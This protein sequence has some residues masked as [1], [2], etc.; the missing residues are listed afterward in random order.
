MDLGV[1]RIALC[2]IIEGKYAV[3]IRAMR[4]H[5]GSQLITRKRVYGMEKFAIIGMACLFPEAHTVNSYW[6]NLLSGRDSRSIATQAQM[7]INPEE[8]FSPTRTPD[9]YYSMRGGYIHDF[10]FNPTGYKLSVD[11]LMALDE[12]HHWSLYAAHEALLDSGYADSDLFRTGVIMG[13]LSFPTRASHQLINSIYSDA[14]YEAISDLLDE[15]LPLQPLEFF[16][17]V[18]PVNASMSGSPAS[19]IA[20]A[21]GLGGTHFALDAACASSLYAVKLAC[22]YL[23]AGKADMM[24][25]GAVSRSDPYNINMG[26]SIFSAYP[27]QDETSS[28][29]N[30]HSAGLVAAEG[31]GFLVIKRLEDALQA[32]DKIV[33]V[34][35]GVGLS[36]DGRGKHLLTPN[37][38]GQIRA[39]ERAYAHSDIT[40]D[41]I[42]YV[43]CHATGTP[44]GDVTELN[45]MQSFFG[46]NQPL[47][48]SVK[49]NLGHLLTAAG[50]S[51]VMKVVLAMQHGQIPATL[52]ITDPLVSDKA[53]W[54][55]GQIVTQTADW[56]DE[57]KIGAV[58][59]FGFGGCNAHLILEQ[60]PL[61]Y[62]PVD[63][64]VRLSPMALVGMDAF[65]GKLDGLQAF[66][67]AIFDGE[68]AFIPLPHERWGGMNPTNVPVGTQATM[69]S[70][71][72]G[73]DVS[74]PYNPA[75]GNGDVPPLYAM[76]RGLGGGAKGAYMTS[77]EMDFLRFKIPP[78]ADDQPIPQQTLMLKVADRALHDA[79]IKEGGNVAVIIA[80]N[81]ELE[82][83]KFRGRVD[84]GWQIRDALARE[85]IALSEDELVRLES[86]ARDALHTWPGVNQYVSFIGNIVANR[87][88][89][90]WDF[91]GASFTLSAE[92]NGVSKALEIAQ[93][94]LT[95]GEADAV[96]VGAVDLS[97]GIENVMVRAQTAPLG[98]TDSPFGWDA[99]NNGWHIGEGAGAV[100]LKTVEKAE[101]DHNRIYAT[102]E[103]ISISHDT[104]PSAE[105]LANAID[106]VS[107]HTFI[108][109]K[110]IQFISL[111]ASGIEA[112]DE[113]EMLGLAYGYRDVPEKIALISSKAVIGHTYNASGMASLIQSA[114]VIHRRTLPPMPN[115]IKPK[116]EAFFHDK[117]FYIPTTTRP[118]VSSDTFYTYG[119]VTIMGADG[120]HAHIFMMANQIS[121][122]IEL[123]YTL[124][125][126][127]GD[128]AND[129]QARL[130]DVISQ[131]QNTTSVDSIQA[132]AISAY[133]DSHPYGGALIGK[134]RDELLSEAQS[135][136]KGIA[137]A[138]EKNR[139]WESK[140]GSS[141]TAKPATGAV[142]LVYPGAFNAYVGMA[143]DLL[144]NF[145]HLYDSSPI[146][147]HNLAS[148]VA[149]KLIYPRT[150]HRLSDEE[151][152][153]QQMALGDNLPAMMQA[154]ST[155]AWQYTRM[156][157]LLGIKPAS[158]LGYSMG[159]A[160]MMWGAEIWTD[161][162]QASYL[163]N[164]TNLFISKVV[165]KKTVARQYF[166]DY[167]TP[168]DALWGNYV[169]AT[170]PDTMRQ[171][172][173]DEPTVFMTHINTPNQVAIAGEKIACERVLG[174]IGAGFV[175][176]MPAVLHCPPTANAHA[177]F[178]RLHNL[179]VSPPPVRTAFMPSTDEDA[180]KRVPTGNPDN[181]PFLHE[182]GRGGKGERGI[183]LY[184][185]DGRT[186][187]I[188]DSN[189]LA[190]ELAH[191]MAQMVDF[192]KLINTAYH[193]GARI[194]IEVGAQ[195]T[196]TR[197]IRDILR[198]K[199]HVAV[200]TNRAGVSDSQS[201][202][203]L[204]AKLISHRV[205]MDLSVLAR[206]SAEATPN[207]KKRLIQKITLGKTPLRDAILSEENVAWAQ[208]L[209]KNFVEPTPIWR[210]MRVMRGQRLINPLAG[211]PLPITIEQ[212][213]DSAMTE[214]Q[215]KLSA[216]QEA[217][218]Q[219]ATQVE[220]A[221]NT[222]PVNESPLSTR[223]GGD[224]GVGT[225]PINYATP[226]HIIWDEKALEEF[227]TG[228]IA[229]V[230]G[231][232]YAI[233]DTYKSRV[234]LPAHPYLLVSRI[235][236]LDAEIHQYRPS[237]MTTEYDIPFDAWYSVDGQIPWAVSVESGQCDLMLI[238]YIGI[239][240]EV[241]GK[242]M[243]RL[244][245]CTLNFLKD[246]PK[247][248]HT[249]RYDIRINSY[250]RNGD[251]LLFFF[252]YDCYVGDEVV[253]T[254]RNG[255]AGFF[256][257]EDLD[258]G[259]GIIMTQ[260]E[261]D[262]RAQI[263][264]KRFEP[265]LHTNKRHFSKADLRKLS[266]G[267]IAGTFAD[268]AYDLGGKSPSLRLPAG[269][270]LL[271]DRIADV[272]PSG[273]AWGL[274][275]IIGEKDLHPTDW[276]FPCH[277]I[278][279]QVM[280]GSLV[281]EGCVQMMQV[282]MMYLGLHLTTDDARFQPI[283]GLPQ[284]VRCRGQVGPQIGKLI[285]RLEIKEIGTSPEPY[286][287]ADVDVILNG[288]IV[289]DFKDLGLKLS[290]KA[291]ADKAIYGRDILR[292]GYIPSLQTVSTTPIAVRDGIA[293][294]KEAFI[295]EWHLEQFAFGSI[296]DCFGEEFRLYDG[297]LTPR[298]PNSELK[299]IS[300]IL[301]VD[302]TRFT[303]DGEPSLI[304]EYDVP[305]DAWYYDRNHSATMPY[306]ILMEIGLQ[307]CGFL[308]AWLGSTLEYP[309]ETYFFR[310][311]DGD[312]KIH[313]LPDLRGK[314]LTNKVVLLSSTS[315]QGMIIQK[316]SYALSADGM[317]FYDGTASFG[318]FTGDALANQVGLDRGN[319][320]Y[321]WTDQNGIIPYVVDLTDEQTLVALQNPPEDKP[322][323]R[324]PPD[325]LI[326]LDRVDV[327]GDGGTHGMGYVHGYKTID[328]TN[329]FYRCHF[330]QDPVMPG[331]LGVEAI[332][333][334]LQVFA[335]TTGLAD[336]FASPRFD[337]L[338]D[339]QF[340]WKYRGQVVPKNDF[341]HLE[342]HISA[343]ERAD[344]GGI[345]LKGNANLWR[346]DIRI[347]EVRGVALKIS[348]GG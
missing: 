243:Y 152:T 345:I 161:A 330:Y 41:Q 42:Q 90:A 27:E 9:K 285:Y 171:A 43:E 307:P 104:R 69:P 219:L 6:E 62:T 75:D 299:L 134:N 308:S 193:D 191:D 287:I 119:A 81:G 54:G 86:I 233:I 290:E 176:A 150:T 232:E 263:V 339:H 56:S 204:I 77:F 175:V 310:N 32:G 179:P 31:A 93:M 225:R 149:D 252:E 155:F 48:G 222:P 266:M 162:N 106:A 136:Q 46:K 66:E 309:Q 98:T 216:H 332:L 253:L 91:S 159:E 322:T 215:D 268:S 168:D 343:I 105:A 256:S 318:Y 165:G 170:D 35:S 173:A 146:H 80:M 139:D 258:A 39:Y 160:S 323:F 23:S 196:C 33:A 294:M 274:G 11:D 247:E 128:S 213:Q 272:N 300:R 188:T 36:N 64:N 297:R 135:A 5:G 123:R 18:S 103:G 137:T 238:S 45:S 99:D 312:G 250:A 226:E 192:P 102:I 289:V 82:L 224:L 227:A 194:F 335:M 254:M 44:L 133:N 320:T 291:P 284:V 344:D 303:F 239:D 7:G 319:P 281:A 63:K 88:S 327:V 212:G 333:Q 111:S 261:R 200:A 202:A 164:T 14:V 107:H 184:G 60:S 218:R 305:L 338:D 236:K 25:A 125:P 277:F 40:P 199:P 117:P 61:E 181:S 317:V 58:S 141:F 78:A 72:E 208:S 190:H 220:A 94:M 231:Q 197:W 207:G 210:D 246:M 298:Q 114:L 251:N 85:G 259:K 147:S 13:N 293:I 53:N 283:H 302:G 156:V 167:T 334:A 282:Y 244:L 157:S 295:N 276:Y 127:S 172:L 113:A 34:V 49:G 26:F 79:Q 121:L 270:M 234:R 17:D 2:P 286:A 346:E 59:A 321:S 65:F 229:N 92:E 97:G 198:D 180:Q 217:L 22:D 331:S 109:P 140:I 248:G 55:A 326:F 51:G 100:V 185:A 329:W 237:A 292:T 38:A 16:D 195:N 221:I 269:E 230:F 249:L 28:P 96:L 348:E 154:G 89:S 275:E 68:P 74:R 235:T 143:G 341:L 118:L 19:I 120:G 30:N 144:Q 187:S 24:L 3:P 101:S 166:G 115:F 29:L 342:I 304:S 142:T 178:V 4:V 296:A 347:Y 182:R 271:L 211:I 325:M 337:H 177:D 148:L 324:L 87:I 205:P 257:L 131:L 67:H 267:D 280:A 138:F 153:A 279:D 124:L 47:I 260:K 95:R 228:K 278:D 315:Y 130:A 8:L 262:A 201:I 71:D 83:H 206:P 163:L 241:K 132:K 316:F 145:T 50:M 255:S 108:I 311:L 264:K 240:F 84:L 183:T 129:L 242:L 186:I 21:L 245:D 12:L 214:H 126:I 151:Y 273:G 169:V 116:H 15:E 301:R 306:S 73:R 1:G 37:S 76:G 122:P 189:A 158:M 328:P 70:D 10:Q 288:K 313:H 57:R 265:L 314:T 203:R 52:H 336:E 20:K 112:E 340:V 110:Y 174:K 209:T 223:W